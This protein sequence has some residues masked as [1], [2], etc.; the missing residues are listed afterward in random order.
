MA[1]KKIQSI[2]RDINNVLPVRDLVIICTNYL[3]PNLSFFVSSRENECWM[4]FDSLSDAIRFALQ[5][6]F[7]FQRGL[8]LRT[9]QLEIFLPFKLLENR[10]H[11]DNTVEIVINGD[12]LFTPMDR[13][14]LINGLFYTEYSD[15]ITQ[16]Y[17]GFDSFAEYAQWKRAW[18]NTISPI[19]SYDCDK[20]G[21]IVERDDLS[22]RLCVICYR[23]F[24]APSTFPCK[25]T[26]NVYW[27]T[28]FVWY[29]G[30]LR[31]VMRAN[32]ASPVHK[33]GRFDP[34]KFWIVLAAAPA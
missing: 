25:K 16:A 1:D 18:V 5:F 13:Y 32:W 9:D 15:G 12:R 10:D 4:T 17:A 28:E 21:H 30:V 3:F 31:R 2:S 24:T 14:K 34:S 8:P 22:A 20:I 26:A 19:D 7:R 11:I 27:G 33:L 23:P 6:S 29:R